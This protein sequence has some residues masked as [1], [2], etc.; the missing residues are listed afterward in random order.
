ML[1]VPVGVNAALVEQCP[2]Q[3]KPRYLPVQ[4]R[5][6]SGLTKYLSG[7]SEGVTRLTK[8]M[9]T[10]NTPTVGDRPECSH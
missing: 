2:I 7:F 8:K 6:T 1:K 9:V 10:P 4:L 3:L 5:K